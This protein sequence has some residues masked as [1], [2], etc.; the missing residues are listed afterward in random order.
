M[1]KRLMFASAIA[2]GGSLAIAPY[3]QANPVDIPFNG[4]VAFECV[5]GAVTPGVLVPVGSPATELSSLA[6]GGV[7]GTT[8]VLCNGQAAIDITAVTKAAGPAFAPVSQTVTVNGNPGL[9]VA[10]GVLTDLFV[11]LEIESAG[12]LPVGDYEYLVTLTAIPN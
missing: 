2:V 10:A 4:S 6:P 9:P 3:A 5:F 1:L 7:A 12:P 8:D 11:D